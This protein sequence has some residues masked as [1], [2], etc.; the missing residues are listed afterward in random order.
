[1]MLTNRR[2]SESFEV[3]WNRIKINIENIKRDIAMLK[4]ITDKLLHIF[5]KTGDIRKLEM[6]NRN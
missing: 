1:M 5:L 6:K 3:V 2:N 4:D